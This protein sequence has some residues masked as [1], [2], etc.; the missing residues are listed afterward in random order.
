MNSSYRNRIVPVKKKNQTSVG[1]RLVSVRCNAVK[2]KRLNVKAIKLRGN[3]L[4]ISGQLE[5]SAPLP[6]G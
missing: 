1:F 3:K 4:G 2:V 5:S 6:A